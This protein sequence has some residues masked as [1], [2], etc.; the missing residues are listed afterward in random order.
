MKIDRNKRE[1]IFP[2][3]LNKIAIAIEL[4]GIVYLLIY[5]TLKF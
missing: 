3:N 5:S 1:I 4:A 2:I